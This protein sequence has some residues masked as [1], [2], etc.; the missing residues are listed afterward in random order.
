MQ[1]VRQA[2]RDW[3]KQLFAAVGESVDGGPRRKWAA[4]QAALTEITEREVTF[5]MKRHDN[6]VLQFDVT[7]PTSRVR[8]PDLS[9]SG[10]TLKR[11]AV[12]PSINHDRTRR[13]HGRSPRLPQ[14]RRDPDAGRAVLHVPLRLRAARL[15]AS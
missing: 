13:L 6:E 7:H 2:L 8:I 3:S 9:T 15:N 5:E 1:I 11:P 4:M 10:A 14:A 12:A